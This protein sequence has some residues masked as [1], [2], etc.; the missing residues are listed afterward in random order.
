[1]IKIPTSDRRVLKA[2]NEFYHNMALP[3]LDRLDDA[4][5]AGTSRIFLDSIEDQLL[6]ILI[7]RPAEIFAMSA[8]I[9][10]TLTPANKEALKTILTTIGLLQKKRQYMT[11]MILPLHL[12]LTYVFIATA[13]TP[14]P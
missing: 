11:L 7:G 4:A 10:Q 9:N 12:K 13:I 6:K 8:A 2:K 3:V 14:I 5:N 1:M